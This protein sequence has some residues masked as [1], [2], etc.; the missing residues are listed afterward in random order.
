MIYLDERI[1]I[2]FTGTGTMPE[3]LYN[4]RL[5][6]CDIYGGTTRLIFVGS[7]YHISGAT[8]ETFDLTDII[9]SRKSSMDVE[10]I[11]IDPNA[12]SLGD[13]YSAPSHSVM[14]YYLRLYNSQ[15]VVLFNRCVTVAMV[16]RYPNV[17]QGITTGDNIFNLVDD[18][19]SGGTEYVQEVAVLLQGNKNDSTTLVSNGM[20]LIP[21][22]PLKET[23]KFH[24]AQTVVI[25][26]EVSSLSVNFR[27]SRTVEGDYGV[28]IPSECYCFTFA[29]K[30]SEMFDWVYYN[31]DLTKDMGLYV[32]YWKEVEDDDPVQYWKP[33]A[34]MDGCP[35][36]YYLMWEDR[37]GGFQSQAFNDNTQYSE[38]FKTTE[39][40]NYKDERK[41]SFISIQP[42]WKL[43]SGWI[44]ENVY[45][46]YE[47][48]LTSPTLRLYDSYEDVLYNVIVD[49]N[50][51]EKTYR[52]EKKLLNLSLDLEAI[53]K[54]EILY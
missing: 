8:T 44:S 32:S 46:I 36:R 43:T 29:T 16:Y 3:G 51:T 31:P 22:Y 34:I 40:I 53:S 45:C 14:S 1:Q 25:G 11:E 50:Y 17:K 52:S 9:R 19:E 7:C 18:V 12:E 42:K 33:F 10:K 2:T 20:Y 5:D 38:D 47:S 37:F 27:Q 41:K 30:P 26:S 48:I 49:T 6:E 21:H 23:D 39:T 24:I 28:K 4:W 54:Q 13:T 15:G 35:K